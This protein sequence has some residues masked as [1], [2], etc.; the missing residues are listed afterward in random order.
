MRVCDQPLKTQR[1]AKPQPPAAAS[2]IRT[3]RPP[4]NY[5]HHQLLPAPRLHRFPFPPDCGVFRRAPWLPIGNGRSSPGSETPAS[6]LSE[7][8]RRLPRR[9]QSRVWT[10]SKS[11][12]RS[13][14]RQKRIG[15]SRRKLFE[16][17]VQPP[18]FF[19]ASDRTSLPLVQRGRFGHNE[20]Q[21]TSLASPPSSTAGGNGPQGASIGPS[22]QMKYPRFHEA[23]HA[24]A[25]ECGIKDTSRQG[26]YH[27]ARF[28]AIAEEL[29]VDTGRDAPFGWSSTAL[30]SRTTA[31]Y[32]E[33]LRALTEALCDYRDRSTALGD[34][35]ARRCEVTLMCDCGHRVRPA[36][37]QSIREAICTR[38]S[39]RDAQHGHLRDRRGL[40]RVARPSGFPE[41]P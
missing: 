2:G 10:P 35:R 19:A 23:V 40:S 3:P 16:S 28:R 20:L 13:C 27:N 31:L 22:H 37:C 24:V 11:A 25:F 33:T 21:T 1:H 29:G 26:R 14:L 38:C 30:P 39:Q 5:R 7:R 8:K 17:V 36:H 15:R 41:R 34:A 32:R 6:R 4:D 12:R 9:P 18:R